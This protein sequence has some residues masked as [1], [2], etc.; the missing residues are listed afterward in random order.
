M[1]KFITILVISFLFSTV[2]ACS[3]TPTKNNNE[4]LLQE[5]KESSDKAFKDDFFKD[6]ASNNTKETKQK[7]IRKTKN[8]T[9]TLI[10]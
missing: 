10:A 1:R 9:P 7:N 4:H 6:E 2:T 8:R 5:I 3:N